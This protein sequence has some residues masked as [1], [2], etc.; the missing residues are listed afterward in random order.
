VPRCFT[1]SYSDRCVRRRFFG[2]QNEP[3][4]AI[5][6]ASFAGLG[7]TDLKSN[8]AICRDCSHGDFGTKEVFHRKS[9]EDYPKERTPGL[10]APVT[11]QVFPLCQSAIQ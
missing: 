5:S 2:K 7:S 9:G 1:H 10:T 4:D 11:Q 3:A 6:N 8:F